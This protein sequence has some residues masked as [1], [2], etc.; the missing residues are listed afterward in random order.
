L[1]RFEGSGSDALVAELRL[2]QAR[3]VTLRRLIAR[4]DDSYVI[5]DLVEPACGHVRW[6][7]PAGTEVT[8]QPGGAAVTEPGFAGRFEGSPGEWQVP[9]PSDKDPASGWEST[10]YGERSPLRVLVVPLDAL[11]RAIAAFAP[12]VEDLLVPDTSDAWWQ[13]I[14]DPTAN[15][16]AGAIR[17]SRVLLSGS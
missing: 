12:R 7:L 13:A 11:G 16:L 8:W 17:N 6:N 4:I 3:S 15:S 2:R 9:D 14:I 10:I 5:A 1:A